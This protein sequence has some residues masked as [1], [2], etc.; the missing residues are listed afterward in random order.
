M[1]RF[2]ANIDEN[3]PNA[4]EGVYTFRIQVVDKG[5]KAFTRVVRVV[6]QKSGHNL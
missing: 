6:V 3:L 2:W 5:I 1:L 4:R